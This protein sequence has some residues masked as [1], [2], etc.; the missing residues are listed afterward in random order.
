M[1]K[2]QLVV[3]IRSEGMGQAAGADGV[4]PGRLEIRKQVRIESHREQ[5]FETLLR[6]S[7]WW[8]HRLRSGSAVSLEP[9][10]GGRFMEDWGGES[11]ALYGF[12]TFVERPAALV[13]SRPMGMQGAAASSWTIELDA[14]A[15]GATVVRIHHSWCGEVDA[16]TRRAYATGWDEGL[17]AL[18]EACAKPARPE[19][20]TH[21]LGGL[22]LGY[23]ISPPRLPDPSQQPHTGA[24][25]PA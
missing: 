1:D 20:P 12:V 19:S 7:E 11:G 8:P 10:V 2:R 5:V 3:L 13:V 21:R 6:V 15:A 22:S 16:E 9:W 25:I 23:T 18:R 4:P 24:Q 17:A 14:D